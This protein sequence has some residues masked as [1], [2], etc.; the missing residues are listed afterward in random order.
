MGVLV[1]SVGCCPKPTGADGKDGQGA[2]HARGPLSMQ[3]I[4]QSFVGARRCELGN[5]LA[6]LVGPM[7]CELS[8]KDGAG[9]GVRCCWNWA[10]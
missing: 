6:R 5:R 2:G 7:P 10:L 4:E 8:C 1:P 9:L 3:T